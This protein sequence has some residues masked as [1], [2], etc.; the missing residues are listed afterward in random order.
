MGAGEEPLDLPAGV[1][2]ESEDEIGFH[3]F[4]WGT[5]DTAAVFMMSPHPAGLSLEMM[6]QMASDAAAQLEPALRKIEGVQNIQQEFRDIR[7]GEFSGKEICCTLRMSDGQTIYQSMYILWDGTQVW[8]G[9]LTGSKEE[10]RERVR[11]ILKW[12]SQ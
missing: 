5:K 10:D 6:D 4:H 3:S 9:Q 8:Q 2:H 11:S 1:I 7:A 12:I